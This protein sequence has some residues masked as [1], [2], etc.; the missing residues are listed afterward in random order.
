[1]S[2]FSLPV[3]QLFNFLLS[4][5]NNPTCF[6]IKV[7]IVK[8][9]QFYDRKLFEPDLATISCKLCAKTLPSRSTVHLFSVERLSDYIIIQETCKC[10]NLRQQSLSVRSYTEE[11]LTHNVKFKEDFPTV[12]GYFLNI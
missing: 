5:S 10:L 2:S 1:M 3:L 8:C 6:L 4:S 12:F 9:I 7:Y 11:Y